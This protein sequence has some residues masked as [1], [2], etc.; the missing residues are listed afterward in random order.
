VQ[1][2]LEEAMGLVTTTRTG[3]HPFENSIREAT[4]YI[5][6][7]CGRNAVN[8]DISADDRRSIREYVT[9]QPAVLDA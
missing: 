7:Q 4:N 9:Q 5:L 2:Q 1:F 8:G 3:S 6:Q